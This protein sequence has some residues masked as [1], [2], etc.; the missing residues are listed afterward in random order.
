MEISKPPDNLNVSDFVYKTIRE[1]IINWNIKPGVMIS[2]KGISEQLGVSRMPVRE[3][4]IKMTKE[5]LVEVLPQRG[6][7]VSK[8]DLD[9]VEEERFIRESL[10]LAV[11][12]KAMTCFPTDIIPILEQNLKHQHEC[13]ESVD[14]ERFLELDQEFHRTIFYGCKREICWQIIQDVSGHYKRIRVMTL[15]SKEALNALIEQHDMLLDAIKKRNIEQARFILQKHL[16]K[17]IDEEKEMMIKYP[18]YF[19]I[20][21]ANGVI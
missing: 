8:I 15:W 16:R 9:R 18:E 20:K 21:D 10:E 7:V 12:D 4:F 2:E 1:N 3:A 13:I 17:L 14:Y 5:G 6:T 19:L 11:L